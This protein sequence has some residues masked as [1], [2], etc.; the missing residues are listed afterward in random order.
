M[1]ADQSEARADYTQPIRGEE[2]RGSRCSDVRDGS[3]LDKTSTFLPQ[4]PLIPES[5][6]KYLDNFETLGSIA[7]I[8]QLEFKSLGLLTARLRCCSSHLHLKVCP[9]LT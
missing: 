9:V 8:I 4:A 7:R 3:G 2:G 5:E 6:I 1:P